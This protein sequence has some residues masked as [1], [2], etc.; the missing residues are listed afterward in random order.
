[1]T[2]NTRLT[3]VAVLAATIGAGSV[4]A[5]AHQ[6]EDR[7]TPKA[8]VTSVDEHVA[9]SY[10][11]LNRPAQPTDTLPTATREHYGKANTTGLNAGLARLALSTETSNVFVAPA[12]DAICVLVVAKRD[13]ST[14]TT[15]AP[16]EVLENE[17]NTPSG[18]IEYDRLALFNLV[19]DGV[20]EVTLAFADGHTERH[21]VENN[22]YYIE[23]TVS[24]EPTTL[25]YEGPNGSVNLDAGVPN[26]AAL[27]QADLPPDPR[28]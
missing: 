5:V 2:R 22:V 21:A 12:Q 10:S 15:C 11:I 23:T 6:S 18:N 7:R 28:R 13:D 1:M 4:A 27:K 8:A 3:A 14:F 26:V 19:P 25:S 24:A 9:A 20:K 16:K 17:R